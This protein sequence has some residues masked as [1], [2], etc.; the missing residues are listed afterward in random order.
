MDI[1]NFLKI[2]IS[3]LI[4]SFSFFIFYFFIRISKNLLFQMIKKKF[5]FFEILSYIINISILKIVLF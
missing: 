4:I 1:L 2:Y 5:K 3:F